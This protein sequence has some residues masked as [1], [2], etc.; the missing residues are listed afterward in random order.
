M[1][2]AYG[3]TLRSGKTATHEEF[4][5]ACKST[6]LLV[7]IQSGVEHDANQA[8]LIKLAQDWTGG[9]YTENFSS[10]DELQRKMVVALHQHAM[11]QSRISVD[12]EEL[13]RRAREF[14]PA[15]TRD[16]ASMPS[17]GVAVACGPHEQLIKQREMADPTIQKSIHSLAKF[18]D[19]AVLSQK[20]ETDIRI[21]HDTF[22]LAQHH[23]EL[24]VNQTGEVFVRQPATK[25][26]AYHDDG[27][28]IDERVAIDAVARALRFAA[29]VIDTPLCQESCRVS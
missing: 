17:V 5:E 7:F 18:G 12:P 28:A 8:E 22:V 2:A 13:L 3:G 27:S 26:T 24:R 20:D 29:Q 6:P 10:P 15:H 21:E 25:H 4:D 19:C 23:A 11:K 9:A 1:G 16:H 14:L